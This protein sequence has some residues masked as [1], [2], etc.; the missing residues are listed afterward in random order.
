M[1]Q[2][3]LEDAGMPWVVLR[4]ALI[5]VALSVSPAPHALAQDKP[6]RIGFL[7]GGLP[8]VPDKPGDLAAFRQ[9]LDGL[10]YQEGRDYV[11]EGQFADT[12]ASRLPALAKELVERRVDVIVT[13]GTP[14]VRAAK[15]ATT[16]IPIIMAGGNDPV[17]N[18]LIASLARPGGNVTGV[19]HNP[20]PEITGKGLQLLKEAAPHIS[21]VAVL[22][23]GVGPESY[24]FP[25]LNVLRVVAGE[26][27]VT[28][29]VHDVT[30]VRSAGD[31]NAIL[32]A[33]MEE[34]ADAVFVFPDFQNRKYKDTLFDFLSTKHRVPS[35]FQHVDLVEEG[36]LLGYYT[37]FFELRRKSASYVDKIFKGASAANLPVEE[38]SRF[39][40]IVNLRTAKMLG[41][42]LPQAI[43]IFADKII[44]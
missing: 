1:R 31:F 19:A 16:T 22:A 30:K 34:R 41:L 27:N 18:G 38:P 43:L 42:M 13:I 10:G 29:L 7:S 9:G 20:G 37:D 17:G 15:E 33:I 32:S 35:M 39:V 4:F 26:L 14:A 28:L 23:A 12:D 2:S 11:I 24:H 25:S 36:G 21:R 3:R 6:W 8:P 5:L 44:E 40:F